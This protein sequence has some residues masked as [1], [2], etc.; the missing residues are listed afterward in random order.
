VKGRWGSGAAALAAL[1]A[2]LLGARTAAAY[3]P[4]HGMMIDSVAAAVAA[5]L[6]KGPAPERPVVLILPIQG[7]TSGSLGQR[8]LERLRAGSADVRVREEK[9][10]PPAGTQPPT[11]PPGTPV[12]TPDTT[13]A[14]AIGPAPVELH[15][16]VD[17][18]SVSFTRR[19]RSFPFGVKGYERLVTMRASATL[20]DPRTGQVSWAR[21][22]TV[23]RSDI[24]SKHDLA[25][26]SA[27]S[28]GFNPAL[29]QGSGFHFIEPLIVVGVVAGLVV[30][31][32]SNRN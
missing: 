13:L 6:L 32:Y 15:A 1:I 26:V 19:I 28:T 7:D 29:P 14:P 8:L 11:L 31:F 22:S 25:Y 2:L 5:D 20:L 9:P 17:G 27:G 24:V 30:L 10:A 3:V 18:I 4:T 12:A 21:S 16:R 23:S